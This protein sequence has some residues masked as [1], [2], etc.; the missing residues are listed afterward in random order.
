MLRDEIL[1]Y[2]DSISKDDDPEIIVAANEENE[3]VRIIKA[4]GTFFYLYFDPTWTF[5]IA[6]AQPGI[7]VKVQIES[8]ILSRFLRAFQSQCNPILKMTEISDRFHVK[9]RLVPNDGYDNGE[10]YLWITGNRFKEEF[11][12]RVLMKLKELLEEH[13]LK[14]YFG[15][16]EEGM[17]KFSGWGFGYI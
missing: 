4:R 15:N 9:A 14:I 8:A 2:L 5:N 13:P 3:S 16:E 6:K 10:M 7:E 17:V 12:L 1:K 11:I